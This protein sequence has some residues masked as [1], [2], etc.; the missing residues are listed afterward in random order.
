MLE[1][2][3]QLFDSFTQTH[4]RYLTNRHAWQ[5]A[6]NREG[7]KVLNVIKEYEDKLCAHSEKGQFNKFSANLAEKFRQEVK[8][9]FPLID[10]VGVKISTSPTHSSLSFK[11]INL[12]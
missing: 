1:D 4:R 3:R 11:K 12:S 8:K 6:F 5:N 7:E 2:H 10:F 9:M